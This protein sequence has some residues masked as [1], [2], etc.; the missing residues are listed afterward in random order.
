MKTL[1]QQ[2]GL[3]FISLLIII[4]LIAFFAL[5]IM[6]VGPLYLENASVNA[7][8]E[9][10]VGLPGIGK[11]GPRAIRRRIQS[12]LDVD[13]VKSFHSKD[14]KIVK[15]KEKQVWL[16]TAEYEAR[17]ILFKN[18]GVFIDFS[19]TVEVPR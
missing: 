17:T 16:V 19:K 15:G 13:S 12:Q 9:N 5:I 8:V 11:E 18:L 14:A 4:A 2:R 3:T 7:S 1:R 10:L 6:K